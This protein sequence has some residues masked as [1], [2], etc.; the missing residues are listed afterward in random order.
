MSDIQFKNEMHKMQF[1]TLQD[2]ILKRNELVEQINAA[3][4]SRDALV[5]NV[6]NSDH[7]EISALRVK[8]AELQDQFD[9]IVE[10]VVSTKMENASGDVEKLTEEVKEHDSTIKP[11]LSYYKKLYDDGSVDEL[12]KLERVKGTRG[13]GGGG[14]GRRIRGYEVVID[15]DGEV[16]AFENFASAA[17]YLGSDT[18]T[19][20]EMFF[21]KAGVEKLKDAPDTVTFQV[22][23]NDVDEDG[24]ETPRT[25]TI[26]AE[27]E[28]KE[29]A[30]KAPS[31]EDLEVI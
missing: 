1:Q 2:M 26:T 18:S 10:Q 25:A 27:R 19:L 14:G 9:A 31:E 15:L 12:P 13:G 23:W 21:A 5:E 8:I 7:P 4:G 30:P 6:E 29:E 22:S 17:K 20:Q 3:T 11:G 24:E 16:T 28:V